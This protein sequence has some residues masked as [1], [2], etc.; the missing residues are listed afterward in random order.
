MGNRIS[1]ER[2]KTVI[3]KGIELMGHPRL[4]EDLFD[5]WLKYS[6]EI[7]KLSSDNPVFISNY[8]QVIL[9]AK[10]SD[11]ETSQ[12]LSM[13]IKYLIGVMTLV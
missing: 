13:C 12:R 9:T 2:I 11:I 8:L 3:D 10:S 1:Y 7:L 6:Q 4:D 5:I